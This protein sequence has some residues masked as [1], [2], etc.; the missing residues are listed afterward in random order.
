MLPFFF[1]ISGKQAIPLQRAGRH[2]QSHNPF[3][4][5][6]THPGENALGIAEG[7]LPESAFQVQFKCTD[8][9]IQVQI[10]IEFFIQFIIT[11]PVCCLNTGFRVTLIDEPVFPV[12]QQFLGIDNLIFH[13]PAVPVACDVKSP[14]HGISALQ[15]DCRLLVALAHCQGAAD[16]IGVCYLHFACT[17]GYLRIALHIQFKRFGDIARAFDRGN[18]LRC[19]HDRPRSAFNIFDGVN[20]TTSV[21]IQI[22]GSCLD[23]L[24]FLPAT[25]YKQSQHQQPR[26]KTSTQNKTHFHKNYHI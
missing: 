20:V 21:N 23:M 17:G 6:A 12:S 1:K 14:A 16:A 18:P 15:A 24:I 8:V 13:A 2:I 5:D 19:L 22:L 10:C 25:C 9:Q 7:I 26:T 11:F 4:I 3:L